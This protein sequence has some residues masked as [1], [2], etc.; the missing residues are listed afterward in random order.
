MELTKPNFNYRIFQNL[1]PSEA[2]VAIISIDNAGIPDQSNLFVLNE[3]GYS[4]GDIPRK[5]YFEKIGFSAVATKDKM[6]ICVVTSVD[7]VKTQILLENNLYSALRAY[8]SQ[9]KSNKVWIPLLGIDVGGLPE[10]EIYN[11]TIR[12][13]NRFHSEYPTDAFFMVSTPSTEKGSSLYASIMNGHKDRSEII[14]EFLANLRCTFYLVDYFHNGRDQSKKFF[15]ENI[16]SRR[17]EALSH[18]ALIRTLVKPGD[19][20]ILVLPFTDV[21]NNRFWEIN[22]I[23]I[24]KE[25]SQDGIT[26]KVDWVIK[27]LSIEIKNGGYF[28]NTI[29]LA[30]AKEIVEVLS[31]LDQ[32]RLQL[33]FPNASQISQGIPIPSNHQSPTTPSEKIAGLLSD[34]EKGD[35]LLKIEKDVKAF[36]RVITAT[37]LQPPL[38][39]ALFGKWGSGKSFFMRKLKDEVKFLSD[40]N[41][42]NMYCKGVVPIHFNAW[43]YMD[44][45]LWASFV[46]KIFEGLNEYISQNSLSDKAKKEIE[47]ELSE[48]LNIAKEETQMLEGKVA[49]LEEQIKQLEAQHKSLKQDIDSKIRKLQTDTAWNVIDKVNEEFGARDRILKALRDN[50]TYVQTEEELK[51]I[52][53]EN[54]WNNPEEAYRQARSKYI[55]L[56]EFFRSEKI[57]RNLVWLAVIIAIIFF[58]PAILQLLE[59]K[60]SQVNFLIPQT[61]LSFL[62]MVGAAWKRAEVVYKKWQPVVSSFW[63][64][65]EE[66]EQKKDEA[67][68]KFEQQEK[69]LKF[70]IEK[71][72][73]ELLSINEQLQKIRSIKTDLEFKINNALATEALYSFIEKRS[74]SEDYKKHLGIISIIRR[75]FEILSGLF[76]DH[77]KEL[78][79]QQKVKEFR[80]KFKK[81][82]QRI[83]L[84]VDDLD[85]CPEENVVQVM[86]AVNLLMA[87]PLFVVI[88]GVDPRW[89]KNALIKK[90]TL[91]FTGKMNGYENMEGVELIEPS[92]YLE[93][94]FQ[95]PFHL[96]NAGDQNVRDM[97]KQLATSSMTPPVTI[98]QSSEIVVPAQ[99]NDE[100]LK[101]ELGHD[102]IEI[103]PQIK[104]STPA[105]T[106]SEPPPEKPL[107]LNELLT[108]NDQEIELM[109][110]MSVII[111]PNPRAIKRFVNIFKIIKAHEDF[112][113][114][115]ADQKSQLLGALFL[116]ALSIGQFR[117]LMNSFG[118][119]IQAGQDKTVADYLTV[120]ELSM[121]NE[122]N[123]VKRRLDDVLSN[124]NNLKDI[125]KLKPNVLKPY[126]QFLQRFTFQ[127]I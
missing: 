30:H 39:I 18:T 61:G 121:Q 14:S 74:K 91:Q 43:S 122:L 123:A 108:F 107:T 35:D 89:I 104:E 5:G 127:E 114:P 24:V 80:G 103:M 71:G 95:V 88:V 65:K 111:G 4:L 58:T 29:S 53:P 124:Q 47:K 79:D 113:L 118:F 97:I 81:P 59:F 57:I 51:Q 42:N 41:P 20:F 54:Y 101:S 32:P 69:A 10:E 28:D 92:N 15:K 16:W 25:K 115:P 48:T 9:I 26:V 17:K 93:K 120:G 68:A 19:V 6:I 12:V 64:V 63:H 106:A 22:A 110:D 119:Y 50:A 21:G 86:E 13:I 3:Y 117:K 72:K 102:I 125:R 109:Q 96:K 34:S 23:G 52:I 11:V 56:K 116:L 40:N 7:G 77:H 99:V 37:S 31:S 70:E 73:D 78:I 100:E 126:F 83:V 98:P 36:A 27:D 33:L 45:N 55:F 60:I 76:T 85:R 38:A 2:D 67:M 94:I 44:A 46:S 90:Y 82:I 1:S 66:Y 62:I 87:F 105:K 49:A 84:Y 112:T 75:D 8:R